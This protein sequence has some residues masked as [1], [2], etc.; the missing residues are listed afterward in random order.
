MKDPPR[1]PKARVRVAVVTNAIPIYRR[2]IF[3]ALQRLPGFEFRIFLSLPPHLS[4]AGALRHLP[5][6]YSRGLNIPF[7]TRHAHLRVAQTEWLHLPILLPWDLLRFSPDIV[8]CGELGPKSLLAYLLARVRRVPLVLWSEATLAHSRG[9]SRLQRWLRTFLI[10]RATAFLAWGEPAAQYLGSFGIDENKIYRC[11]QA[12]DNDFWMRESARCD[13]EATR[14]QLNFRGKV[15]LAVGRLVPLK[16]FD[17][18]LRAWAGVAVE[19][20]DRHML[21]LVGAGPEESALRRLADALGL[22]HIVFAGAQSPRDLVNYY[23]AAD[24]VVV[25]SL[26]D[27]WGLV[28]NEAMA[29]GLPVLGSKYA[30]ASQQLIRDDS[31]GEL[32]DPLD[33]ADFTA[34]LQ[35]WCMRVD[36][37][38]SPSSVAAVSALRFEVSIDALRRVIADHVPMSMGDVSFD[39]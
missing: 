7:K 6:H 39:T 38:P 2:P 32:F 16:G 34:K 10:S 29:C 35:R 8:I 11:V 25:P 5:V 27:V 22:R 12:V 33:V 23:A 37:V 4:D 30:G 1:P 36:R 21:V 14:T 31:V 26:V 20:R 19:V 13:R 9:I 24:V 3:E 18:L 28:V 17:Y 15:F